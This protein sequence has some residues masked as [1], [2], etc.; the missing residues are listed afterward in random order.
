[1]ALKKVK[2]CKNCK[3]SYMLENH[4]CYFDFETKAGDMS[5]LPRIPLTMCHKETSW[6]KAGEVIRSNSTCRAYKR[7]AEGNQQ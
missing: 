3:Y 1:M 7:D 6:K 5:T 2:S 4:P